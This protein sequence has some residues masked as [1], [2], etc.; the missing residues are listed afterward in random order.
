MSSRTSQDN[1]EDSEYGS[2]I[3]NHPLVKLSDFETW[4]K[5]TLSVPYLDEAELE[6]YQLLKYCIEQ[7]KTIFSAYIIHVHG[8]E[9]SGDKI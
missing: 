4:L 1:I 2:E 9:H 5:I 3:F 6:E 7:I 8:S